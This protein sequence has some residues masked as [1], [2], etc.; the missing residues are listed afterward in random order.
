MATGIGS[1]AVQITG[2][3]TGLSSAFKDAANKSEKF[4]KDIDGKGK[5]QIDKASAA[6]PKYGQELG[7][8][9]DRGITSGLSSL[10]NPLALMGG[11]GALCPGG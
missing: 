2:S 6:M 4:R 7:K 3:T 8:S 10:V 9:V 5:T 1:L 11:A